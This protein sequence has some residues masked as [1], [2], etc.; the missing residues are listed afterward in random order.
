[1]L[2][3]SDE[4]KYCLNLIGNNKSLVDS[5]V[6]HFIS[7]MKQDRNKKKLTLSCIKKIYGYNVLR[8][9]K[10]FLDNDHCLIFKLKKLS[11][12]DRKIIILYVFAG[13]CDTEQIDEVELRL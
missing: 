9:D 8:I 1:M 2:S 3:V 10:A 6:D 11:K 12:K 5:L 13:V 7:H 4:D